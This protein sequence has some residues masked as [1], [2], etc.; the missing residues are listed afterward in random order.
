MALRGAPCARRPASGAQAR[1]GAWVGGSVPCDRMKNRKDLPVTESTSAWS[2][3]RLA[4]T[5][6][7][8]T[9]FGVPVNERRT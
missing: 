3:M 6:M 7:T 9:S 1:R 2:S 5:T 8:D 4:K